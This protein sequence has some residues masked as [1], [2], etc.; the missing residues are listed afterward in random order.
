[1]T[2]VERYREFVRGLSVNPVGRAG[3]ILTTSSFL[4]FVFMELLRLL[5]VL[6][7]AYIG[8]ITYLLLPT[9][10]AVGLALIPLGWWLYRKARARAD[11]ELLAERFSPDAVAPRPGGS[12][13]F[14]TVAVFTLV[15]IL[16]LTA[17]SMRMLTF[18]DT[19][20]FCGTACHKV[21]HPEWATYQVS[22]HAR[23]RC[24]DCHVG[25]GVDALVDSKLNGARQMFLAMFNAYERPV[26][27]PVRQLRPARET[28]E[29]CHWPDKFYG[30]RQQVRV[31]Y[32]MD[33]DSTPRYTTLNLKID[34]GEAAGHAG[35]HWH[36]AEANAVRYASAEDERKEMLWV[37]VRRP[38]GTWRRFAR[39][40]RPVTPAPEEWQRTLD[41]VDCHNRATHIYEEPEVAVDERIRRGLMDRSLPF[42]R[43]EVLGA[44]LPD[45]PDREAAMAGIATRLEGAYARRLPAMTA[46]QRQAL[47]RTITAAQAVYNRNIH[48]LMAV[49]W[50]TYPS[51]LDHRH[52]GGCFRCHNQ[53][54]V[55]ATGAAV[56]HDCTLCHSFLAYASAGPYQFLDT[57]ADDDPEAAMHRY[58]R[59][60]F[61]RQGE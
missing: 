16:F 33:R 45:Y 35:I 58:L 12:R 51:H 6:T 27:T 4:T 50:G 49:R 9:L 52:D 30:Y 2:L 60:E 55:D 61:L 44:L 29:K 18:M 39:R 28:C 15:N 25:E 42:V 48:P 20:V 22:P 36:V 5:G 7:N 17:A 31:H 3:V 46:G 59:E 47:E 23:V 1:M 34:T 54:L 41:C 57:P 24:V 43:R 14:V 13:L 19:P 21:M 40:G 10:F 26:P 56:P 11:R 8:L 53:E 37:E 32:G 38:D